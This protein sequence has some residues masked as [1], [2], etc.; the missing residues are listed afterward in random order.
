VARPR[1]WQPFD[2]VTWASQHEFTDSGD[3]RDRHRNL[4]PIGDGDVSLRLYDTARKMTLPRREVLALEYFGAPTPYQC[5]ICGKL[6]HTDVL[7]LDGDTRNFARSNLKYGSTARGR[8]HELDCLRWA[9]IHNHVP[10]RIQTQIR[11]KSVYRSNS[12]PKKS[13]AE[14]RNNE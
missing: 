9:M 12:M 7:H 3:I 2:N 14:R 4:I 6:L 8:E 5:C 11:D 1:I 10:P 13:Q